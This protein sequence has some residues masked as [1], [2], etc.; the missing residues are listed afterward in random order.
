MLFGAAAG[1]YVANLGGE[2]M[3]GCWQRHESSLRDGG[4]AVT[5]LIADVS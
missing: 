3:L 4:A 1:L 2:H 5:G